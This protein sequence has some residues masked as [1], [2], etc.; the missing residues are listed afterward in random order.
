M[1]NS[2]PEFKVDFTAAIAERGAETVW[3]ELNES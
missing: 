3:R 1:R 2:L